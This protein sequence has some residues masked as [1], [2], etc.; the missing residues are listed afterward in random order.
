MAKQPKGTK[1][2]RVSVILPVYNAEKFLR[3]AL[4]SIL[5]QTFTELE[6]IA[7]DD[8]S[9]D[10]SWELL[11]EYARADTRV[12]IFQNAENLKL[13]KTLN[14]AISEARGEYVAR[15]DSDDISLPGRVR[16][17]VEY[18]DAHPKVG[19]SGGSMQIMNEQGALIGVRRYHL[20]DAEI[21]KHLFRYSPF[22]HPTIILRQSVLAQ[23]GGYDHSFNPAE[24]YE[25]Y[26][27]LGRISKFGN[28]PQTLLQYRVVPKSMTTGSTRAM[29]S[30]TLEIRRK[31]VREYGY[32]MTPI[33]R[34]YGF[35]QWITMFLMPGRV[36]VW[37]FNT[38][39]GWKKNSSEAVDES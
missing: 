1:A 11:Q 19:V 23:A 27:R 12:R 7:V 31:A 24:D 5:E 38:L 15:M 13:S 28:V 10:K 8:G 26:F 2:P 16:I 37:L 6:V 29:E 25:L 21:R 35:M 34:M 9:R 36:R 14:R 4:E 17:Q 18:M 30:K 32:A 20:T 22:S 33:D 39:R 3:P